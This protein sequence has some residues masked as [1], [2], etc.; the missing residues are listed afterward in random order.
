MLFVLA[1]S[2]VLGFVLLYNAIGTLSLTPW[3]QCTTKLWA[4]VW[5]AM[6]SIALAINLG[7]TYPVLKV[8]SPPH[9]TFTRLMVVTWMHIAVGIIWPAVVLIYMNSRTVKQAY[10]HIADGAATM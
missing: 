2:F 4:I 3:S 7:W 5:L 10:K 6:A 9:F 1:T 8:A